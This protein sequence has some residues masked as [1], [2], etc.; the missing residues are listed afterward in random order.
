MWY[1]VQEL[2][3]EGHNKSQISRSLGLDRSTVRRY[4]NMTEEEFQ[5]WLSNIHKLPKKLRKYY[6]YVKSLLEAHHYLSASQVEDRL[7]EDFTDLPEVH[8]KTVYNFVQNIRSAHDIRKC[9]DRKPREYEKMLEPDYG[10]QAQVDFGQYSMLTASG[11]RKKVYFFAM[12]LCRSRQKYVFFQIQPF[13]SSTTIIAHEKALEYFG[14]QPHEI[15]YDQDRVIIVEENLGDILATREFGLYFKQMDF[16]PIFCRKSDPESKGKIENVVGFI[17]KNFLCG[18]NFNGEDNLN[19]SALNWLDRTG[20]GKEHAGIKKIPQKEWEIEREYLLPLKP[21]PY[22]LAYQDVK[23]YKV[24]KD[25]TVNYKSNFY[26]LPLGTYQ[27]PESWVLLK[28]ENEQVKLSATG[29]DLL[30]SHP[31]SYLRGATVYNTDHRRNKSQSISIL[32]EVVLQKLPN[33]QQ[34][35]FYIEQMHRDKP[36]YIRD[37]LLVIEKYLPELGQ[38]YI[39]KAIDFCLENNINNAYQLVEV[40]R[41]YKNEQLK[42]S[43]M[44]IEIPEIESNCVFEL[45]KINPKKSKISTYENLM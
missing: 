21:P 45:S 26:T 20:N 8:S 4:Q 15:I 23:R 10:H 18:R 25:N 12:V 9:K 31:I 32:K 17:K 38:E 44:R 2:I 19:I 43:K 33:V 30:S 14:G 40:A 28:V 29:G 42:Q 11:G 41:H 27:G 13:T 7:K 34:V 3:N 16:K 35:V 22:Q 39:L 37:S 24:R 5:Q 6:G 1:K 36:R